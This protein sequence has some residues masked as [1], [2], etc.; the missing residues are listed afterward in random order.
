MVSERDKKGA[1]FEKN[2][3]SF[4]YSKSSVQQDIM[5]CRY[6]LVSVELRHTVMALLPSS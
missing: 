4:A 6:V 2:T 5:L 3:L 1:A